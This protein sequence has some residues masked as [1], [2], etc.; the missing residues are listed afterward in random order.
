[1]NFLSIVYPYRPNVEGSDA[2]FKHQINVQHP[3]LDCSCSGV[4]VN[5]LNEI[6]LFAIKNLNG[7]S[8]FY[9]L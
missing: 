7:P 3:T 4:G 1:M 8:T 2:L 5:I 9:F 6:K